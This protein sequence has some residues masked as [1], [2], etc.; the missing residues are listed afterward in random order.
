[1]VPEEEIRQLILDNASESAE[2]K[3][4]NLISAALGAGGRDNIT[5][6]VVM[7]K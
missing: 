7:V 3:T 4:K 6:I 2:E 5:T 1:M